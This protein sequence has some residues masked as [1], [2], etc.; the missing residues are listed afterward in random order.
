MTHKYLRAIGFSK[1]KS[2][3]SVEP[4]LHAVV[5]GSLQTC[6][7]QEEDVVCGQ[8]S[9]DFG[10]DFGL[11]VYGEFTEENVFHPEYFF[12]YVKSDI[13]S[14]KEVSTVER[15]YDRNAYGAMCED[16]TLGV[17]LIFYLCNGLEYARRSVSKTETNQIKGVFLS[18]LSLNGMIIL[19]VDKGL[20]GGSNARTS[21]L[22]RNL[23]MEAAWNGDEKALEDLTIDDMNLAQ[24]VGERSA[25]EDIY[26]IVHTSFMPFGLESDQY[27]IVGIIEEYKLVKNHLTDEE[28]Y[29][30]IINCNEMRFT[31]M[32][33]RLD[34]LGAPDVGRRFKGEIWLQGFARFAK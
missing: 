22:S 29:R 31:V 6:L 24:E 8:L 4:L 32:I 13:I 1:Y 20:Q 14:T 19:P 23:L 17:S 2:T 28:M 10:E 5:H 3:H 27:S 25:H 21:V 12:P 18:A 33:N 15:Y 34:L 16:P 7:V 30:M 11:S 9:R 26:T